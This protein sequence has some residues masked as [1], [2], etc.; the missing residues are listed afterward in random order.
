MKPTTDLI[1]RK[2][3]IKTLSQRLLSDQLVIV[4]GR[5]RV[6]KSRLLTH[7]LEKNRGYY[8]QAIEGP[9]SVQIEQLYLDLKPLFQRSA[10][11]P[12]TWSE[13]FELLGMLNKNTPQ[14]IIL[15]IDEMPYLFKMDPSLPSILQKFID[16][17]L[18][19]KMLLILCGSGQQAMHRYFSENQAPLYGRADWTL[20]VQP[21]GYLDFC[22]YAKLDSSLLKNFSLFSLG[23]GLPKYWKLLLPY[24]HTEEAAVTAADELFF[25]DSSPLED[26]PWRVLRDENIEG[27]S[28]QQLLEVIGRGAHR[29]S[30][31]AARLE[32][33][34]TTLSKSLAL[35]LDLQLIQREIPFGADAKNSKKALYQIQDPLLRFWFSTFSPHRTRWRT[36]TPT[37]KKELIHLH[38][39]KIFEKEVRA[40]LGQA[41]RYWNSEVEIDGLAHTTPSTTQ[42]FEVKFRALTAREKAEHLAKLRSKI[43]LTPFAQSECQVIGWN[44]FCAMSIST[45]SQTP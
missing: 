26:E 42:A 29:P 21:M 2:N 8:S 22:E 32:A 12:K 24:A 44:E 27:V 20:K 10:L 30:E 43:L 3:E 34:Q 18:P 5:R 6:G 16:H 38:A 31:M 45:H 13:F 33:K 14:Q 25:S 41:E 17:Q 15:C 4:T 11:T 37:Q 9:V 36:Y 39:S 1:N 23:G 40:H 7:W 28:L 35:L 19:P